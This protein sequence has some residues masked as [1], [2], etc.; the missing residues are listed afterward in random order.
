ML[1]IP[2][3]HAKRFCLQALLWSGLLFETRCDGTR[4]LS[5]TPGGG[6]STALP[7]ITI[8]TTLAYKPTP[9]PGGARQASVG[10][11]RQPDRG[12][13][14]GLDEREAY[15]HTV[16]PQNLTIQ[17]CIDGCASLTL[18]KNGSER[19]TYAGLRNGSV[20]ICGVQ[21][22]PEAT[23]LSEDECSSQY[24]GGPKLTYSGPD[25]VIVYSL[26]GTAG[27]IGTTQGIGICG[28]PG[29]GSENSNTLSLVSSQDSVHGI[30]QSSASGYIPNS[31][32]DYN[33][34]TGSGYS[35]TS[36]PSYG[37]AIASGQSQ[38]NGLGYSQSAI[39]GAG[40]ANSEG[41]SQSNGDTAPASNDAS[42]TATASSGLSSETEVPLPGHSTSP[43]STRTDGL[44][45][46][47][48]HTHLSASTDANLTT[49]GKGSTASSSDTEQS[50]ATSKANT[51]KEYKGKNA[52]FPGLPTSAPPGAPPAPASTQ[53][54]TAVTG[55]MSG[56]ILLAAGLLLCFRAY[57][58]RKK[59]QNLHVKM[60]VDR[61]ARP[62]PSPINTTTARAHHDRGRGSAHHDNDIRLTTE[63]DLAPT[64][65]A[66]ESGG[67]SP[68]SL[69]G[70]AGLHPRG[71]APATDRDSLYSAL[72]GDVRSGP[73]TASSGV[74][75]R[76]NGPA[77]AS[78]LPAT[79]L[80]LPQQHT[81]ASRHPSDV[82]GSP[83]AA[84]VRTH[85]ADRGSAA[86]PAA[87]RVSGLGD[88][89]WRRRKLSTPYQPVSHTGG[90]RNNNHNSTITANIALRGPPSGPPN[91]PLPPTPQHP[92]YQRPPPPLRPQRSFDTIQELKEGV[93][94]SPEAGFGPGIVGCAHGNASTP[95]LATTYGSRAPSPTGGGLAAPR[96]VVRAEAKTRPGP[97]IEDDSPVLG[98]D[99]VGGGGDW[100]ASPRRGVEGDGVR[101]PGQG[102]GQ[103]HG[104]V[105]WSAPMLPRIEPGEQFDS[106]R[107]RGTIYAESTSTG[108]E[109]ERNPASA[110]TVGTDILYTSQEKGI[111]TAPGFP[112][113][114]IY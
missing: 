111:G 85:A 87:A 19:Y 16:P 4:A 51:D 65:P 22:S 59:Q 10:C 34:I 33:Q 93:Q 24:A 37:Q 70:S 101:V 71:V 20:C 46:Q 90:N 61:H 45:I 66:L 26:G 113:G 58:R 57:K 89:A 73:A 62:V 98:R 21:L 8:T 88:R 94:R 78:R 86:P 36:E 114:G 49:H 63:R 107:W 74:Q 96:D 77:H 7:T 27:N 42:G 75:W 60:V 5:E 18:P 76:G 13:T 48:P 83:H 47:V 92:T 102:R 69:P 44:I 56:A 108:N 11:F 82:S 40:L 100:G 68:Y 9:A 15:P 28:S 109:G 17:S 112:D 50:K 67:R 23:K 43:T 25:I 79:P 64:T 53:T 105:D 95:S 72:M 103:G 54:I 29:G 14:L 2:D 41:I 35:Q 84:N 30:G 80:P 3:F 38:S 106:R 99:A 110:T 1:R 6:T 12:P 52:A 97:G 39:Q 81:R 55:S 31:S 32:P 91:A 104:E